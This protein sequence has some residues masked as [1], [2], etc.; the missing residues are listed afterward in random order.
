MQLG[1]RK[2]MMVGMDIELKASTSL[3]AVS[4][5]SEGVMLVDSIRAYS[6]EMACKEGRQYDDKPQLASL[7]WTDCF[8][9]GSS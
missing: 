6:C 4:R 3:S 7:T 5:W 8:S 1:A 2:E 9:Y